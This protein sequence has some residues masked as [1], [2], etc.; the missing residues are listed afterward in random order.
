[1]PNKKIAIISGASAGI[2]RE[3][4]LSVDRDYSLDEIWVIARREERLKELQDKCK[5]TV[6]PLPLDLLKDESI[7]EFSDL[8]ETEKPEIELLVNAAGCGYFGKFEDLDMDKQIQS[9]KLNSVALTEICHI[10][11]PYMKKGSAIINLGSNS[12]WQPVPYMTVYGASKSYVL[13]FSRAL[14]R[15]LRSKGIKVICVCP[16]WVKTEFQEIAGHDKYVKYVD[17]WFEPSEVADQA[18]K[19]LETGKTVSIL[20]SNVRRQVRL[21][22]FAPT[23][24]VMDTWYKQQKLEE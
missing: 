2:G 8:L 24:F 20:G 10:A 21:V 1:M 7:K 5:N 16:G 12:A 9:L 23:D 6:R 4:V 17:K 11:L 14:G 13:N 22:K 15:E 18:L 19:D 3:F